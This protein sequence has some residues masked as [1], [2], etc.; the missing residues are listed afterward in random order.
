LLLSNLGKKEFFWGKSLV[1]SKENVLMEN[2]KER[3]NKKIETNKGFKEE[4]CKNIFNS[5]I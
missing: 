1:R 5:C 4:S 3:E 2:A